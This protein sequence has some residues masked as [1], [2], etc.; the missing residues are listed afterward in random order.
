MEE[1]KAYEL[2]CSAEKDL[3]ELYNK[4]DETVLFNQKKVLN[5]FRDAEVALRHMQGSSGYGYEDIS[6]PKLCE[7]FAKIFNTEDAYVS[8]LITCGTHA[9]FSCLAGILRPGELLL[10]VS[11][12]PYDTLHPGV[13]SDSHPSSW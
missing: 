11:G 8:P 1:N 9:I 7:V 10:S 4:I 2:V 6:R 3:V 13:H 12:A 5:A